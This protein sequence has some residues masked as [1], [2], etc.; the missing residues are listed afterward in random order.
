MTMNRI[1]QLLNQ[2]AEFL[3]YDEYFLVS[4]EFGRVFVS[5]D[6]ACQLRS[7]LGRI[8]QPRWLEFRDCTGSYIR[9][10]TRQLS[11]IVESTPRTRAADRN[12]IRARHEEE[13]A[14]QR[15]TEF[16]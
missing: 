4:G 16:D 12:F 15:P 14:N 11:V 13:S 3:E 1:L 5:R 8:I 10:R 2:R 9:V 6:V 7:I